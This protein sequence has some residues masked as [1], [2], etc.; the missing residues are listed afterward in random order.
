ML[1]EGDPRTFA[2]RS[3][4]D[5]AIIGI[6]VVDKVSGTIMMDVMDRSEPPFVPERIV[7]A[8][9]SEDIIAT[10]WI[11]YTPDLMNAPRVK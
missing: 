6:S 7:Y 1:R 8:P 4:D 9:S 5:T 10:D 2:R 3:W 11:E